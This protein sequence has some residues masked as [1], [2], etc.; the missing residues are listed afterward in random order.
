[1]KNVYFFGCSHT[2][3]SEL[4]DDE[5]FPWKAECN[6]V[7]EY[8]KR[9]VFP[10]DYDERCKKLAYPALV[11]SSTVN[12]F[13][14]GIVATGTKQLVFSVLEFLHKNKD[15]DFLYFQIPPPLREIVV[16]YSGSLFSLQISSYPLAF[17]EYFKHKKHSHKFLTQYA[18]EDLMDIITLHGYLDS[19]G[20]KHK[21]IELF[22][23]I[24]NVRFVELID[25][26]FNFL[27][28]EYKKLPILNLCDNLKD[29]KPMLGGHRDKDAHIEIARIITSDLSANGILEQ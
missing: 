1:M 4:I 12:T 29:F 13:N 26:K 14:H 28:E 27:I 3:G 11:A 10:H 7:D 25:T 2:L 20:I 22:T 6:T 16:D 19:L 21:F 18:I 9:R 5:I 8:I 24:T 17:H 23:W 15:V